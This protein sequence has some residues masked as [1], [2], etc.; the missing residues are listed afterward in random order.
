MADFLSKQNQTVHTLQDIIPSYKGSGGCNWVIG[1]G[2][3]CFMITMC[4]LLCEYV[5]Y[6]HGQHFMHQEH[7][8]PTS[9]T[10]T[11]QL[12]ATYWQVSTC[13]IIYCC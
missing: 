11:F 6:V 1:Q 4:I 3:N 7:S 5:E 9:V 2:N 8:L 12:A 13:I 10:I